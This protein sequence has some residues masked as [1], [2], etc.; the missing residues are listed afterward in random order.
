MTIPPSHSFGGL[1]LLSM[2][3]IPRI[4]ED[5]RYLVAQA[6]RRPRGFYSTKRA[7]QLSGIP[8]STINQWA[9]SDVLVPDWNSLHPRGWS[10]RDLLF[11]RLLAWLRKKEMRLSHASDRVHLIRDVL[12]TDHI[13]PTV[14]ADRRHAFLA[15]ETFDRFSR[16]Q[17]FDNMTLF[18]SIFD[19]AQPID[20][21]SQ[22]AMW[23]PGL[24]YPS[25]HTH[26]SPWV[27]A[28]EPC[29]ARSRIPTSALFALRRQR[30]LTAEKIN[31]LYS[32]ITLDAIKDAIDLEKRLRA[33]GSHTDATAA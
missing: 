17:A 12:A 20:G 33:A 29:V 27:L 5:D 30:Q 21:V 1:T 7:S 25:A 11:L 8:Q 23:G 14:R 16:Q 26:I 9:R 3:E 24:I 18:L 6:L 22:A 2:N 31:A 32:H 28:G 15:D 13:D 10:Y 4:S 19:I